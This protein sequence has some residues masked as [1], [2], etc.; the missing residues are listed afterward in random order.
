M[1][2]VA[3]NAL[4]T[5]DRL[6]RDGFTVLSTE[7]AAQQEIRELHVGLLNMMPDAALEAT[8]RQFYRLVGESNPIAQFYMHPFTLPNL[9]RGETAQAHIAQFYES[10]DAIREKGLDALIITGAN[11]SHPNLADEPFWQPLIEV[12]D[13][14]WEHVTSTLCSCLATHAVMQFRYGQ[15]RIKQQQKIWGVFEHRVTDG[16]HPLVADVNTRF[17]VPHSRWNDVSRTQ[18]DAAGVKVLVESA[19]AGVH[20]AVSGDGLRTVLFQGHPEYDTVSLLKEY[21]RDLLLA[22]SGKLAA[23]PPFPQRYFNRQAQ[24]LLSE[25]GRRMQAGETLAFPESQVLPLLDNTWHDTAEAVVGNWIGCV[26]Q[27]THRERGL[28]FMPGIDPNDPLGLA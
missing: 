28:P 21:K 19:E 5:F 3:H 9:P 10:F 11:V 20:L 23:F 8:E 7:R 12:I 4:P 22:A 13:W 16:R 14:A 18:F 15:T 2:L 1:P 26:Y 25:F 27:V 6:R 24:A 17:D